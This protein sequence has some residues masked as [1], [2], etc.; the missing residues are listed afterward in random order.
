[1]GKKKTTSKKPGVGE[2]RFEEA[3][4]RLEAIIDRIERGEVGLEESLT[5]YERGVGLIRRCREILDKAEQRI[6]ELSVEDGP[7]RGDE[8][9]GGS[10][11]MESSADEEPP[12]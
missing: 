5:E 7:G 4:E 11:P 10:R 1:M 3:I 9:G 8:V 2:V 12:F 6:A